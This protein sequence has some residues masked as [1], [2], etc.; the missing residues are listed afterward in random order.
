VLGDDA[1]GGA[2]LGVPRNRYVLPVGRAAAGDAEGV[3]DDVER[4]AA[5][6]GTPVSLGSTRPTAQ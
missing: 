6:T 2:Y 4:A 3:D 5:S 1:L